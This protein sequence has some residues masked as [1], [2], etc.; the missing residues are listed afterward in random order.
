MAIEDEY[1]DLLV[2]DTSMMRAFA[3]AVAWLQKN[4]DKARDLKRRADCLVEAQRE[5]GLPLPEDH[6]DLAAVE[7]V[8]FM[9]QPL[10]EGML[11]ASDAELDRP[12]GIE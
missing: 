5:M 4:K 10:F 11:Q 6:R 9:P 3:E 1:A 7:G 2:K 12:D 8:L